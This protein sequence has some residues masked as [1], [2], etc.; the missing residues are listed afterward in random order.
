MFS[1]RCNL[2]ISYKKFAYGRNDVDLKNNGMTIF[3]QEMINHM[4]INVKTSIGICLKT[5][6]QYENY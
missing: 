4:R 3:F 6:T 5:I 2:H 1:S